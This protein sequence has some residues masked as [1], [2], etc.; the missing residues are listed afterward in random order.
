M[1]ARAGYDANVRLLF[2]QDRGINESLAVTEVAAALRRDGHKVAV[3][4]EASE[5]DP[6]GA[7]RAWR[8]DL[9]VVPCSVVDPG[10]PARIVPALRARLGVPVVLGGSLPTLWPEALSFIEADLA[11]RGEAETPLRFIAHA[12][13][14]GEDAR[15]LP[16]RPGIVAFRDGALIDAPPAPVVEDL[17]ALPLPARDLYY[18][19]YPA[20]G[21]FRW[22]KFLASRG[23]VRGCDFCYLSGV[24]AYYGRGSRRVRTKSVSRVIDE[25]RAVRRRWPLRRVHF[26]DDAFAARADWAEELAE[27]WP[28]EVGLPFT[29]NTLAELLTERTV[30]ALAR[31]GCVA[32]AVGVEVGDAGTRRDRYGKPTP[33]EVFRQAAERLRAHGIA[34]VA[35]HMIGGP[36]ETPESV[37]KALALAR[38]LGARYA[39]V[40]LVGPMPGTP[41]HRQVQQAGLL[42]GDRPLDA[43]LGAS[44]AF[45]VERA[46]EILNLFHLFR[47]GVMFP[48]VARAAPALARL[49]LRPLHPLLGLSASLTEKRLHG[50]G[51]IEG[52]RYYRHAGPPQSRTTHFPSLP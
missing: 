41:F 24:Q 31:A 35:L 48:A 21:R 22:K 23:C 43:P 32:V 20:I 38:S 19:R 42:R 45:A 51:L 33:D 40:T 37:L 14:E 49:P 50:V 3:L 34:L 18:A 47:L 11:V 29:C 52:F 10:F 17:D 9:V 7:A 25:V 46:D 5:P 36:G 26:S 2:F 13:E 8:P 4:L 27:R 28:G 12:L 6:L 15:A 44:L 39:R 30:A 16:G 1:T